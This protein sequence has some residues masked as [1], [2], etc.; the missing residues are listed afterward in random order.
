MSFL[1]PLFLLGAL[2]VAL[3]VVFHLIRR[4]S[5]EQIPF[6]SLIFLRPTPPRVTRRNR[7]EHLFLLLLRCL[8]IGL[9]ACAFARPFV[10]KPLPPP[11]VETARKVI[12]LLD[13]SA[14][15]RREGLWTAALAK[16]AAVLDS[17]SPS[18]Q[19]AVFA[20]D[21]KIRPVVTFAQWSALGQGERAA[22]AGRRLA[23]LQPGWD[24]THLG[25]ALSTA[26]EAFAEADEQGQNIGRRQLVVVTDLQEGSRLDGLQGYDWPRG[27]EVRLEPVRPAGPTNAGLQWVLDADDFRPAAEAGPRIRVSNSSN[28]SR[29]QFRLRWDGLSGVPALDVYVPPSQ[30]RVVAAPPLPSGAAA[31]RL[32]LSGDDDDFDNA[33]FIVPQP[34]QRIQVLFLGEEPPQDPALPFYYLQRAFQQTRRQAVLL[35]QQPAGSTLTREQL[36]GVR[37]VIA[38]DSLPEAQTATLGTF[39]AEGG[40]VLFGLKTNTAALTVGRL[41]GVDDLPVSEVKPPAYAMLELVDFEHPLFAPFADPRYNDF[42]KIHFWRYRRLETNRLPGARVLAR[43]D[44]GDAAVVEIPR[45]EGRLLVLASGWHAADSQMARSSKFVPLLYSVLELAGGLRAQ[46]AQVRVREAVH[47]AGVAAAPVGQPLAVRKP[48]GT[49]VQLAAGEDRFTQTD[50]PGI[51]TVSSAE[52]PVR[53]AVNLDAAESRTALLPFDTLERLGVPLK[54]RDSTPARQLEQRRHLLRAE[55]ENQQK[56]WRWLTVAAL[57]VL[58]VE[59]W[60]AGWLTRRATPLPPG[61]P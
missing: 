56:L 45:G 10:V 20:F 34:A 61:T 32:V 44:S 57:V 53:F 37:L 5:K 41:A 26:A 55:L 24:S 23:D 47:L 42:T 59:T 3:P 49:R 9:V 4:Q 39:L 40:T 15:M 27:I 25:E 21:R 50:L 31:T 28:A 12:V 18:D 46:V 48:D 43:F 33:V 17:A 54:P 52:P 6:S 58:I 11:P 60:L 2:T 35:K 29:E 1:A 51:Y 14:S 19:V 30:S 22:V 36:A 38:T 8:V 16:A 7:L 13:T